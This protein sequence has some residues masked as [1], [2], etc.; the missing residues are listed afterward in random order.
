MTSYTL[1]VG[2]LVSLVLFSEVASANKSNK[3]N[4][5]EQKTGVLVEAY[6]MP[7][8]NGLD[9]PP[10]PVPPDID[11]C[12]QVGGAYYTGIS[13][14]W[15]VPWATKANQM[16]AFQGQKVEKVILEAVA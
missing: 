16:L 10:W 4:K 6:S 13:R 11:F 5:S 12:F 8:C 15:G 7:R 1:I 9:C 14:P 3:S 2:P